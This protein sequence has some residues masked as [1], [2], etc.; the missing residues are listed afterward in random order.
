METMDF[1]P[2]WTPQVYGTA[3][4]V[5]F[6]TAV[7]LQGL[8]GIGFTDV[9]HSF[10]DG[11]DARPGTLGSIRTDVLLRNDIGDII[12]IYD[13]KTGQAGLSPGRVREIRRHTGVLS[14]VPIIEL[15]ILRNASIKASSLRVLARLWRPEDHQ[16]NEDLAEDQ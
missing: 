3:V 9:E 6:G 13:V 12:A 10:I 15:H 1:I 14:N 8:R 2:E 5:A 16:G 4:H 11:E 7:R